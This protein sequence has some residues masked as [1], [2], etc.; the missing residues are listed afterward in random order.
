MPHNVINKSNKYAKCTVIYDSKVDL[1]LSKIYELQNHW[2]GCDGVDPSTC[3]YWAHARCADITVKKS[4]T[5]RK[6][7]EIITPPFKCPKHSK[8]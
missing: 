3:H 6:K 2:I 7:Y 1:S 4:K 8:T 5:K